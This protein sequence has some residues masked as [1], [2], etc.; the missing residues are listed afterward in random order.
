MG[1][2]Y[3]LSLKQQILVIKWRSQGGGIHSKIGSRGTL[4]LLFLSHG[5]NE[6]RE[7]QRG[8]SPQGFGGSSEFWWKPWTGQWEGQRA[9]RSW[10]MRPLHKPGVHTRHCFSPEAGG[11]EGFSG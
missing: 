1:S 4:E 8:L 9:G 6:M 3:F 11:L 10:S 7:P 5:R 2:R